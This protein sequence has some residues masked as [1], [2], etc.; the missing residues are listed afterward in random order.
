LL[1]EDCGRICHYP[2]PLRRVRTHSLLSIKKQGLLLP[3]PQEA[4]TNDILFVDFPWA[5]KSLPPIPLFTS[6]Y[7]RSKISPP[8]LQRGGENTPSPLLSGRVSRTHPPPPGFKERGEMFPPFLLTPK[9]LFFR[10]KEKV[11]LI[12]E[13]VFPRIIVSRITVGFSFFED[14]SRPHVFHIPQL[15]PPSVPK[16]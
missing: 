11:V 13:Q 5:R 7:H 16:H 9:A 1:R 10:K 15:F 12:K 8:P 14:L 3:L 4:I 2:F 6:L